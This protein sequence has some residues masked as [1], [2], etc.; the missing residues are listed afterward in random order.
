[1]EA[2]ISLYVN[3]SE[4]TTIYSPV[5]DLLEE[6]TRALDEGEE[7]DDDAEE[8]IR[9]VDAELRLLEPAFTAEYKMIIS[10]RREARDCENC[11]MCT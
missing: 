3:G 4:V 2:T 7:I 5:E 10:K 9:L 6:L 8:L 1:M 11:V